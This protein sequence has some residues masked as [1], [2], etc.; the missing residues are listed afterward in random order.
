MGDVVVIDTDG[1]FCYVG[2]LD[3]VSVHTVTVSDVA[4]YNRHEA[5]I[6]LE[7][8]LIECVKFGGATARREVIVARLR[9]ISMSR[10]GDVIVP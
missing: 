4:I 3:A 5:R 1:P 2:R 10:L 7:Q 8:F 9:V 6:P